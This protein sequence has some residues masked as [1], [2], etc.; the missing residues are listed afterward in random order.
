MKLK[1][2]IPPKGLTIK[3]AVRFGKPTIEGTRVAV[4]DILGL[5]EAGYTVNEIPEQ[6]PNVT[7]PKAKTALRYATNLL[8]KE[9]LLLVS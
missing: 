3:Q 1:A 5:M 4:A 9:E 2:T 7:L 8:G 6:Y